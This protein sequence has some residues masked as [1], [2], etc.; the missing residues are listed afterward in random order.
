[1]WIEGGT[2]DIG[3]VGRHL[4]EGAAEDAQVPRADGSVFGYIADH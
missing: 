1:L 4:A 3:G 2:Y